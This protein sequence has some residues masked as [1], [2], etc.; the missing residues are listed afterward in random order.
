MAL[1]SLTVNAK[2]LGSTNYKPI[3]DQKTGEIVAEQPLEKQ[4][5]GFSIELATEADYAKANE[6]GLTIYTP[7]KTAENPDPKP[8]IRATASQ[9]VTMFD[10]VHGKI[11]KEV[12]SDATTP[13][14]EILNAKIELV[15]GNKVDND[16]FRVSS[17]LIEPET[18]INEMINNP[19]EL[20]LSKLSISEPEIT[21]YLPS[22][23]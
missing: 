6:L 5:K 20:D 14:F 4:R 11:T 10:T 13:N 21:A 3:T 22:A 15:K 12:F 23:E 8:F 17:I 19:F 16:F 1:I 18:E 2:R 9:T 7:E